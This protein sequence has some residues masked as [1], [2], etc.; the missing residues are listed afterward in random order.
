MS[1]VISA[2]SPPRKFLNF[3][4]IAVS[5]E[6]YKECN[7][8]KWRKTVTFTPVFTPQEQFLAYQADVKLTVE[9]PCDTANFLYLF[10]S[11]VVQL[12]TTRHSNAFKKFLDSSVSIMFS[13]QV[14]VNLSDGFLSV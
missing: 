4:T 7:F 12:L 14:P 8:Y 11:S 5:T 13:Y 10:D 1:R 6:L 3:P 9:I 2:R